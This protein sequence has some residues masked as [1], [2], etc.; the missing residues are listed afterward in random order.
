MALSKERA[1]LLGQW[2]WRADR[3]WSV[4]QALAGFRVAA[5]KIARIRPAERRKVVAECPQCSTRF[6]VRPSVREAEQVRLWI[7]YNDKGAPMLYRSA[8]ESRRRVYLG[9][10]RRLLKDPRQIPA[11]DP[12]MPRRWFEVGRVLWRSGILYKRDR[13][14]GRERMLGW[15]GHKATTAR[16]GTKKHH[17]PFGKAGPPKS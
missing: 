14:S 17:S 12:E 13:Q 8:G 3:D 5:R 1:E 7:Q 9:P 16:L 2:M 11:T 10:A 4:G 15:Q 6:Y